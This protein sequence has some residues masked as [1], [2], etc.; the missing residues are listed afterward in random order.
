MLTLILFLSTQ[1]LRHF[2]ENAVCRKRSHAPYP[3]PNPEEIRSKS[4]F[5]GLSFY[6]IIMQTE[7]KMF[8]S[9]RGT[10]F[11]TKGRA[12]VQLTG[13]YD[14][15]LYKLTLNISTPLFG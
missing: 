14:S 2:V 6:G 9:F 13:T 12:S 11:S 10:T 4:I 3:N 8:L 1:P 15:S 5:R 7:L